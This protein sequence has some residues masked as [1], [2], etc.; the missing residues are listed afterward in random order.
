MPARMALPGPPNLFPGFGTFDFVKDPLGTLARDTERYG[1]LYHAR[2][3][4]AQLYV[5]NDPEYARIVLHE[6]SKGFVKSRQ[7]EVLKHLTGN[8]LIT[9][10]GAEWTRQRR[11]VMPA[12]RKKMVDGFATA[13]VAQTEAALEG[14]AELESVNAASEMVKIALHIVGAT[15]LSTSCDLADT[16]MG[17][18]FYST[19]AH[20]GFMQRNPLQPPLWVPTP[21]NVRF[22]RGRK[23]IESF[24]L[25]VIRER[26]S[27]R[28]PPDD[29]LTLLMSAKDEETGEALD[30]QQLLEQVLTFFLTAFETTATTLTWIWWALGTHEEIERKLLRELDQQLGT[31]APTAAD[32]RR[33]PYL[34][35]IMK[36]VLRLFPPAWALGRSPV[37][38][39]AI[40]PYVIPAGADVLISP[41]IIHRLPSEWSDPER[42]DPDRFLPD[43]ERA[44]HPYAYIPFGGGP[45]TC[46]GDHFA[47]LEVVSVVSTIARKYRLEPTEPERVA[48]EPAAVL[49]LK[50]GRLP[51]RL[52][53]RSASSDRVRSHTELG[54]ALAS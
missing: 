48:T 21:G 50:G 37:C 5:V 27:L 18:A 24:V 34:S 35:Q 19:V 41:Y 52:I 46:I 13:M 36:E 33:L 17:R 3:G 25:E 40:G 1:G 45:R 43:A 31:R 2:V 42:F 38:D 8:G 51:M 32:A 20:I 44:R 7:Y 15:V 11:T 9:A 29:L 6:R 14:W 53:R 54:S 10:E 39:E 12:M 22:N 23:V 26:R 16:K 49:R 30:D 47:A 28:S 4:P